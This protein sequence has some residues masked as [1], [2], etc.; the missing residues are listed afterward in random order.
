MSKERLLSAFSELEPV[1]ESEKNFDEGRIKE[2]R[3]KNFRLKDKFSNPKIK[4]IR[5]N[6]CDMGSKIKN[7]S[8][9]KNRRGWRNSSLIR[10]ESL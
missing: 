2:I 8:H 5:R 3:E 6:L 9:S 1:K 7:P 4:E 10:K